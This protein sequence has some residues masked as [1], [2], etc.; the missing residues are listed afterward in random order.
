MPDASPEVLPAWRRVAE[1]LVQREVLADRVRRGGPVGLPA[2]PPRGP[3]IDR[4]VES[5]LLDDSAASI[6]QTLAQR[7]DRLAAVAAGF[8][9]P[10][11]AARH[12]LAN[13]LAIDGLFAI[14]AANAGLDG[15][16]AEVL[17]LLL[18]VE[19]DPSLQ[20][21]VAWL[22]GGVPGGR[23]TLG[24]LRRLTSDDPAGVAAVPSGMT[25]VTAGAAVTAVPS[26]AVR[27]A[28]VRSAAV[29]GP[30]VW[31][32]APDGALT[33]AGYVTVDDEGPWA[34]RV[35][36]VEPAVIW[37]LLGDQSRDP[38]L[39]ADLEVHHC[40]EPGDRRLRLVAVHGGDRW[41]R[42]QT[43]AAAAAASRY[44]VAPAPSVEAGWRSLVREATIRGCGVVLEVDGG[45]TAEARRWLERATQVVWV[46]SS[47]AQLPLDSL[48]RRAWQELEA[49][50]EPAGTAEWTEL[51]PGAQV[52]RHPL[53]ADQIRHVA[54]A[55]DAVGGDLDAAVRRLASGAIDRLARRVR[56][57]RTWDDLV[58]PA[59]RR[60]ELAEVVARYRHRALV[61]GRWGYRLGQAN[62][63]VALF[64]GPSGT[65]KTLAAEIIA[66]D[67]GLDLFTIDLSAMVSKYI[68][69]TEK[70][71]EEVFNAASA[72][73]VVLLFDEADSLFGK[74]SEVNEAKDRYA[75][76]EVSYLLQRIE[77]YDGIAILT[78]NLLKNI[79]HAFLRRIDVLAEFAL[80]EP[81]ERLALW[82]LGFPA[83]APMGPDVD[84]E[85][86]ADR[87]KLAGGN[88]HSVCLTAAFLAA[89]GEGVITIVEVVEGLKREYAKL[90][91]LRTAEEFG[92][93]L[94]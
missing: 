49:G 89:E 34:A 64:H 32:V 1:L 15:A 68:G 24:L 59:G 42:R 27:S 23:L 61:H 28:A 93:W 57:R 60:T 71:L 31:A 2:E 85:A 3:E 84:L 10:L 6:D 87:F 26:A 67:L 66:N 39:P 77:R 43:G 56:P 4:L 86:L 50:D 75:N 38:H 48:P 54:R 58:L 20:R 53:S 40:G 52:G 74:R 21:L 30:A 92:P 18:A 47:A 81:D 90:G 55:Y 78:T 72:A 11:L 12:G 41:R 76:I 17:A 79:D 91:R 51:L 94:S 25:A 44:L 5:L 9:A 29:P 83:S 69:E 45:L 37:A 14:L 46:L 65:G 82:R 8:A 33:R 80:P 36:S 16:G 7:R 70:N 62:G 13:E 73:N 88:I 35:V 22:L 19:L 63:V